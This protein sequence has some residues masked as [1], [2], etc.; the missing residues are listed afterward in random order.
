MTA[1]EPALPR[2][3]GPAR[4]RWH[5]AGCPGRA[6]CLPW[7]QGRKGALAHPLH[8]SCLGTGPYW[9]RVNREE[10]R[11]SRRAGFPAPVP[12]CQQFAR[13]AHS[14]GEDTGLPG[15]GKAGSVQLRWLPRGQPWHIPDP[16]KARAGGGWE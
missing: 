4:V 8:V 13:P 5:V 6:G 15:E 7:S 14:S 3:H 16:G 11:L 1:V 2:E 9:W 10:R 12:G